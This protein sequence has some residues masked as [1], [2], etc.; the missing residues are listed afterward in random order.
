M[1]N[2]DDF[3]NDGGVEVGDY[4]SSERTNQLIPANGQNI[5]GFGYDKLQSIMELTESVELLRTFDNNAL[6]RSLCIN[7]RGSQGYYGD[8]A[9][10]ITKLDFNDQ[11]SNVVFTTSTAVNGFFDSCCNDV[12]N[13]IF[14]LALLLAT[15]DL[16]CVFSLDAGANWSEVAIDTTTF[17]TT[18]IPASNN[19]IQRGLIQCN[20]EGDEIRVILTM[21]NAVDF[22]VI[23]ESTDS[24]STWNE[25]L[26]PRLA[27]NNPNSNAQSEISRDLSTTVIFD[28][29]IHLY[30]SVG[31][32]GTLTDVIA[33]FTRVLAPPTDRVAVSDDGSA[34]CIF[35]IIPQQNRLIFD[36]TT[37][38][39]VNWFTQRLDLDL[40]GSDDKTTT[41]I[42]MFFDPNDANIMYALL[43]QGII[44]KIN[45]SSFS[46]ARVGLLG[47]NNEDFNTSV[48][49]IQS[50]F[51]ANNAGFTYGIGD[52][53]TED[54]LIAVNIPTGML[55]L[56]RISENKA[57]K[58]FA[59]PQTN[60][61]NTFGFD[62]LRLTSP[63]VLDILCGY[64]SADKEDIL[65]GL[66]SGGL[67]LSVNSGVTFTLPTHGFTTDVQACDG[68]DVAGTLLIASATGTVRR[69]TNGGT[70]WAAATGLSN[71]GASNDDIYHVCSC[72]ADGSTVIAAARAGDIDISTNSGA[73][74]IPIGDPTPFSG[75]SNT[76]LRSGVIAKGDVLIIFVGNEGGL[77]KVSTDGGANFVDPT[78][79]PVASV[80]DDNVFEIACSSDGS[81]AIALV[82]DK[83]FLSTDTGDNWAEVAAGYSESNYR[84][85]SMSDDGTKIFITDGDGVL[86]RSLDSGVSFQKTLVDW[87]TGRR[88]AKGIEMS[89]DGTVAY[90]LANE[91]L[92]YRAVPPV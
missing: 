70:S 90:S 51:K 89:P 81:A 22:T 14:F 57:A 15:D 82:G 42:S 7:S 58:I 13:R 23:Y 84:G 76:K 59:G 91:G 10:D 12:G 53:Q 79:P 56:D 77:I 71:T 17:S 18:A 1:S 21:D 5:F 41:L 29:D 45:I 24:G 78:T 49:H 4:L 3:F 36:T 2:F 72:I 62:W 66:A 37:D 9:T 33:N 74:F 83:L 55:L 28:D 38:D 44:Y 69:S 11:T 43:A 34:V 39:G 92:I 48:T 68:A 88:A 80:G 67:V 86:I 25:I 64:V 30:I 85:V 40:S 47:T 60:G 63:T 87:A 19:G 52:S 61:S 73:S 8:F 31:G 50:D 16:Y 27:L 20:P 65:G 32:T 35:S 6:T 26:T 54:K 46:V 75:E